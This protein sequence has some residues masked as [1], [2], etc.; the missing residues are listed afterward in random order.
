MV[1]VF[2][3]QAVAGVFPMLATVGGFH[4]RAVGAHGKAAVDVLEPDIEQRRF[5]FQIFELLG[6]GRAAVLAGEDLRV[7]ADGPAVHVIDEE[8]R[9]QQGPGRDLGLGPGCALVIGIQDVPTIPDRHQALAGVDDI[10]HQAFGGLGRFNGIDNIGCW[11][12]RG[13]RRRRQ[14]G[15]AQH[16]ERCG[17]QREFA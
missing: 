10:E 6:P 11:R 8:H 16:R 12:R 15:R 3:V 17:Q 14:H 2:V 13:Q 4:Q 7:M 9:R 1:L 5:A